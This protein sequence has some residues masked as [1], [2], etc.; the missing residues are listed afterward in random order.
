MLSPSLCASL[1][2]QCHALS[3]PLCLSR[4][5]VSCSLPLCLSR[6]AVPCG[7]Y[8]LMVLIFV[9]NGWNIHGNGWVKEQK[10]WPSIHEYFPFNSSL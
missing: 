6:N 5:A 8:V 3:L 2:M 10:V 9:F 1:G 4:N 7:K